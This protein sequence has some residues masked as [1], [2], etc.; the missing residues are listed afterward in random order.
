MSSPTPG[1]D[2]QQYL[3]RKL[4][5]HLTSVEFFGLFP[6]GI[7]GVLAETDICVF[8]A[9][10]K[11]PECLPGS[12]GGRPGVIGSS[13]GGMLDMLEDG[14]YGLNVAPHRAFALSEGH[15]LAA[16]G[17]ARR[18]ALGQ[19][20]REKVLSRI[21][22][23]ASDASGRKLRRALSAVGSSDRNIKWLWLFKRLIHLHS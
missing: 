5:R 1:L 22:W 10:G 7:P 17:P 14:K 2:M 4:A 8:P 3:E 20:A 15:R 19:A 12:D 9:V 21:L 6:S 23:S 18:M 11:L 13:A 16:G